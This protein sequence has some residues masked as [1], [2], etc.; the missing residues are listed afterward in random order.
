M[1]LSSGFSPSGF[2]NRNSQTLFTVFHELMP[3]A[4]EGEVLF[5]AAPWSFSAH[6][7]LLQAISILKTRRSAMIPAGWAFPC[8]RIQASE[9][10]CRTS[11]INRPPSVQIRLTLMFGVFCLQAAESRNSVDEGFCDLQQN[12]GSTGIPKTR[13]INGLPV[14]FWQ[15]QDWCESFFFSQAEL[16]ISEDWQYSLIG[17]PDSAFG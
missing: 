16:T 10:V 1:P 9:C 3:R 6:D 11:I 4:Q 5:M 14:F 8:A 2:E 15:H 7:A 13:G 17:F 12:S